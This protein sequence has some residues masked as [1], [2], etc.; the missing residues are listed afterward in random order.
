MNVATR[1]ADWHN[2]AQ[3][4][5]FCLGSL[6]GLVLAFAS[7]RVMAHASMPHAALR[8]LVWSVLACAPALIGCGESARDAKMANTDADTKADGQAVPDN[9]DA[10]AHFSACPRL[11]DT[12]SNGCALPCI[13]SD[14]GY[15]PQ[16]NC[17]KPSSGARCEQV[18]VECQY[19][20]G[21]HN[22]VGACTCIAPAGEPFWACS[23]G[24]ES[25][26]PNAAPLSGD[27]C[28]AVPAGFWCFYF[29]EDKDRACECLSSGAGKTWW[30]E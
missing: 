6:A 27:S 29:V 10:A 5:W 20:G 8:A 24:G 3:R 4:A 9:A 30:C 1:C 15:G 22:A 28:A 23:S 19:P 12:S 14:L 13:C 18:G 11:G 2:V 21:G 26:C 25:I 17:L 7:P 16:W